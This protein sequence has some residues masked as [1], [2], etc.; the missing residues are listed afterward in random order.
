[1]PAGQRY[2]GGG[3][4]NG[5]VIVLVKSWVY[6]TNA[7]DEGGVVSLQVASPEPI[8]RDQQERRVGTVRGEG[9]E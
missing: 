5:L 7:V 2:F 9:S 3:L 1:M 4:E 6:R 8:Q